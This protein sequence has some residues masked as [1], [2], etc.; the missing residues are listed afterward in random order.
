MSTYRKQLIKEHF[1]L[2]CN[3]GYFDLNRYF[4]N[5]EDAMKNVEFMGG[6][7]IYHIGLGQSFLIPYET[8]TDFQEF[9]LSGDTNDIPQAYLQEKK[10]IGFEHIVFIKK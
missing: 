3:T 1:N 10:R 6:I 9:L 2:D 7:S 5:K 4:E 8:R